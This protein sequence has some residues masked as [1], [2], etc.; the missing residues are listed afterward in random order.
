M[1]SAIFAVA[2]LGVSKKRS[3]NFSTSWGKRA[4]T[5]SS[6]PDM[7][8]AAKG[9]NQKRSVNFSSSWGKRAGKTTNSESAQSPKPEMTSAAKG[10]NPKRFF[11]FSSTWGKWAATGSP[12]LEMESAAKG[13]NQK[14]SYN[15][16]YIWHK[17]VARPGVA[18]ES[19]KP[20][21]ESSKCQNEKSSANISQ[22]QRGYFNFSHFLGMWVASRNPDP[23]IESAKCQNQKRSINFTSSWGKRASKT[24]NIESAGSPKPEMES[25]AKGQNK[26]RSFNFSSAWGKRAAILSPEPKMESAK[27]QNKKRSFNFTSSWGKRASKTT[28]SESEPI[29]GYA[30][31]NQYHLDQLIAKQNVS[32]SSHFFKKNNYDIQI[33]SK[34]ESYEKLP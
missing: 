22:N 7:E 1:T 15:F 5:G 33:K 34:I 8:L 10:Q 29:N 3:L 30:L 17:R 28:N 6:K 12:E 11:N 27:G 26:K 16:W 13:Q 19:P 9:Q 14:R 24:T 25:S 18:T 21:M 32:K 23:E 31:I 4:A 2:T 20:D